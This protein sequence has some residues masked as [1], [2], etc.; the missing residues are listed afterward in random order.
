MKKEGIITLK[1]LERLY[2][3]VE[4][5][6]MSEDMIIKEWKKPFLWVLYFFIGYKTISKSFIF[7]YVE[8]R[9]VI[10]LI[11]TKDL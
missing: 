1:Q 10:Y 2:R 5:Y 3:K 11:K 8:W 6:D 7:Y 4:M 9:N